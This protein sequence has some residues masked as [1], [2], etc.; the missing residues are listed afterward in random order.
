MDDDDGESRWREWRKSVLDRQSMSAVKAAVSANLL[1]LSDQ[2]DDLS[3]LVSLIT[4]VMPRNEAPEDLPRRILSQFGSV[5]SLLSAPED[6]LR[7]VRGVGTH[8]VAAPRLFRKVKQ[9]LSASQPFAGR[10]SAG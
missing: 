5:A 8:M 7:G 4:I 9:R 3:L 1:D 6:A 2:S 10:S